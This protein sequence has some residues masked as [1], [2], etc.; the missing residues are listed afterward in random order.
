MSYGNERDVEVPAVVEFVRRHVPKAAR[1]SLLDVGAHGSHAT[2]APLLR[3]LVSRQRYAAID[4]IHDPATEA[5]VDEWTTGDLIA[6]PIRDRYDAV[7]C[8]S[9]IEHVGIKPWRSDTAKEERLLMFF[10]LL[11]IARSAVLLTAPFGH[12]AV[13]NEYACVTPDELATWSAIASLM[14]FTDPSNA[15]RFYLGENPQGLQ[16]WREVTHAEASKRGTAG[17]PFVVMVMEL[18]RP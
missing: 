12:G 9:V 15:A 4:K 17:A 3:E 14:G 11:R 13:T 7:T 6:L 1:M 2:Y 10:S 8:V 5:I 18:V 16:G